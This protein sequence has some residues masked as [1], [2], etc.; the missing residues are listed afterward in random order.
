MFSG[1][2]PGHIL[3]CKGGLD[4]TER[5][6]AALQKE[7]NRGVKN[8]KTDGTRCFSIQ[9]TVPTCKQTRR[10]NGDT[11]LGALGGVAVILLSPIG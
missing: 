8:C 6:V 10:L 1:L 5:E 7:K 3:T 11:N 2:F 9:S 4:V